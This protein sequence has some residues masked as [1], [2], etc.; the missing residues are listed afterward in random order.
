MLDAPRPSTTPAADLVTTAQTMGARFAQGAASRDAERGLPYAEMA[1]LAASGILGARIPVTHGGPEADFLDVAR[2]FVA[3]GKGDPNIAQCIQPHVCLL[4]K[5]RLYADTDQQ[6][7][8]FAAVS[9]GALITNANAERGGKLVGDTSTMLRREGAGFRLNGT[10][11]YATGSL[12][13]QMF[14]ITAV[15]GDGLRAIAIVPV[16][17]PGVTIVDDWDGLGQRT[18]ASGT[19]RLQEV[20]IAADEIMWLPDYGRRRTHEGAAAQLYHAAIDAGIALA[21]LDDAVMYGRTRARPVPEAGVDRVADDPYVLHSIGEMATMAY[22]AVA[23]VERAA[24]ILD[25]AAALL[26][27]GAPANPALIEASIAVAMAKAAANDASLRVA[28]MVFRVGGASASLRTHNL[29]RHWR[30]A[31]T[32]TLHDPVAY[33][34]RMVGEFYMND[35]APPITT[36]Y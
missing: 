7:R 6:D 17:R 12:F 32:H 18:T 15:G 14:Y 13:A 24:S 21:A 8:Y 22:G 5:L 29:D 27:H 10:K 36:K 26:L 20:S 25:R 4:E 31:R 30:N 34:N 35:R 1:E 28:E 9:R 19:T 2:I 33:K 23:M 3:L 16:D 11:F